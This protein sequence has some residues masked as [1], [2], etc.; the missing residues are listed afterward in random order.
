ML[1]VN[2]MINVMII[3]QPPVMPAHGNFLLA[4]AAGLRKYVYGNANGFTVMEFI[5]GLSGTTLIHLVHHNKNQ[6]PLPF[7]PD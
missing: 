3:G 2:V 7:P 5:S 6:T 4:G 1:N